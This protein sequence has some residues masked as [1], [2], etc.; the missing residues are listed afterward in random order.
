M[1]IVVAAVIALLVVAAARAAF[2]DN[3]PE[4]GTPPHDRCHA[5]PAAVDAGR[6]D[7]AY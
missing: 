4:W 5:V 7:V 3:V 2:D 1:R 6:T